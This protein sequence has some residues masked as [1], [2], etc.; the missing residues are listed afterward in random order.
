[1]HAEAEGPHAWPKDPK[2]WAG[3]GLVVNCWFNSWDLLGF[4]IRSH[5]H[6]CLYIYIYISLYDHHYYAYIY[7][8]IIHFLHT[9]ICISMYNHVNVCAMYMCRINIGN[10]W[11]YIY[12]WFNYW[13]HQ[14]YLL[15]STMMEKLVNNDQQPMFIS[16]LGHAPRAC[17]LKD[18]S[19]HSH[20][21]RLLGSWGSQDKIMFWCGKVIGAAMGCS[22]KAYWHQ[23]WFLDLQHACVYFYTYLHIWYVI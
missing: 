18:D 20:S 21:F 5:T 16:S 13:Y 12:C 11:Q 17:G 6:I 23:G 14:N 1:M 9:D 2:W 3:R 19:D 15:W 8:Y 10:T 7:I 22:R 4:Q